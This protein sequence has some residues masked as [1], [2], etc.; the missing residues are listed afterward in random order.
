MHFS[1]IKTSICIIGAGP[2]GVVT[3]LFL[4]KQGIKSV[5]LDK[6]SFPRQKPCADCVTGNALRILKEI[7]PEFINGLVQ[8]GHLLPIGGIN[9]YSSNH[10]KIKFDFLPLEPNT[11]EPSCYTIQRESFD[12]YL[13]EEAKNTGFVT[14]LENFTVSN[15][16][17]TSTQVEIQGKN[18][19]NIIADCVVNATGSN[20]KLDEKLFGV[21]P[22]QDH[23]AIGIRTYFKNIDLANAD[24]C[25]LYLSRKLMPGGMYVSPMPNNEVNVNMVVRLDK[26]KKHKID[27]KQTFEDFLENNPLAKAKFANATQLRNFE[28]SQLKLGT[29]KRTI[30]RER[31]IMVGDAAGLIDILSANGM[32][33]A[34]MSGKIAAEHLS[35]CVEKND[36]SE[37]R[38]KAYEK[39]VFKRTKNYLKMGRISAPFMKSEFVLDMANYVLNTFSSQIENNKA[40]EAIVY[41]KK[42][43]NPFT[44]INPKYYKRFFFGMKN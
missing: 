39:Q 3:A 9:A 43:K 2:A 16:N 23:T 1:P 10:S 24:F 14:V 6:S 41:G 44:R 33:Q 13:L 27:L 38:L 32:P 15:L 19:E 7:N 28:G 18:G 5:L 17:F 25:E 31:Y 30:H 11:A 26:Q 22:K 4:A 29:L 20:G 35:K 40:L 12:T 8:T 37:K 34:F 42:S 36:F 21:K